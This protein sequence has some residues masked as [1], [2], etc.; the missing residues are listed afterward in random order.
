MRRG[1]IVGGRTAGAGFRERG[2]LAGVLLLWGAPLMAAQWQVQPSVAVA[3]TYSDNI[4]LAPA[5]R[6]ESDFVTQITPGVTVHGQSARSSVDLNYR[7]QNLIYASDGDRNNTNNE[8]NAKAKLELSKDRLFLDAH[9]AISQQIVDPNGRVGVD[10]LSLGNR[11]TV[12]TYGASPTLKLRM[13]SYVESLFQ[14]SADR[15]ET[16]SNQIS[17]AGVDTYTVHFGSGS[18]FRRLLWGINYHRQDLNRDSGPDSRRESSDADV[19]YRLSSTWSFL[20]LGGYEDSN[21]TQSNLVRNGGYWSAGLEWKPSRKLTA[22]ATAGDG[23]KSARIALEPSERTAF[24]LGYRN[25]D[26]GLI[27][28]KSWDASLTH[29]TRL[30]TLQM[31]YTEEN[32]STQ[33]LQVTGQQFFLVQDSKGNILVDPATG[34]PVILVQNIFGLSD[35]EFVRKRSQLTF[36]V[37][38]ARSDVIL[39][40]FNESRDYLL[41]KTSEEVLGASAS[42]NWKFGW[43]THSLIGTSWQRR[44]PS[45]TDG[46]DDLW[47]ANVSLIRAIARDTSASVSYSHLARSSYLPSLTYD[48]NRLTVQLVKSF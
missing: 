38:T 13:R 46:H 11:A 19:R 17:D 28:G 14:V 4:A 22:S 10:N 23:D 30:T 43:R 33:T 9:S 40:A 39:S 37:N 27:V 15:V 47:T 16:G 2:T 7:L 3:E 25:R 41:S 21:L 31:S 35:D 34:Q 44:N 42:W 20:V 5:G 1:C 12:I 8:L 18:A 48:E 32:T 26:V 45:G 29:R 36:G 24:V 6:E